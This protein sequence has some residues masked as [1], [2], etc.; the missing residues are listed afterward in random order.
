MNGYTRGSLNIGEEFYRFCTLIGGSKNI[1]KIW[2]YS[3]N[4]FLTRSLGDGTIVDGKIF[5]HSKMVLWH[6][7]E[8]KIHF[9]YGN[10][11]YRVQK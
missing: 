5:Q 4:K 2:R 8:K 10:L 3:S 1:K 7:F 9:S 11:T 6:G